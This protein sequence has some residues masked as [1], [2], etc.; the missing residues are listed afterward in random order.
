M[1]DP[2]TPPPP[3]TV[4]LAYDELP[5]GSDLR[6]AYDVGGG[7]TITAP[8]GELSP[9]V[10]RSASLGEALAAGV[11]CGVAL[12][13]GALLLIPMIRSN[14]LDPSL[15]APAIVTLGVL[16]ASVYL[17]VW[18]VLYSSRTYV[19]SDLRRQSTVFHADARRLL[20]ETSGPLGDRSFDI[21]VGDILSISV[22]AQ[23]LS[24]AASAESVPC[25]RIGIRAMPH[26][27]LLGGHH[28]AELHWVA[29]SLSEFI[30]APAVT[31]E[32]KSA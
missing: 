16:C 31:T 26:L 9:A 29:A 19:L 20:V 13:A 32:P 6:R 7:V 22:T 17:L 3:Q 30:G 1:S 21:A 12:L 5:E 8:A 11:V 4:R 15:R 14:R 18:R 10:R 2:L 28:P 27:S 25:L 24:S 23:G